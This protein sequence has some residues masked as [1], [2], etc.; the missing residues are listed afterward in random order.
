MKAAFAAWNNRI[1]PVF[2]VAHEVHV[3]EAESGRILAETRQSLPDDPPAQ[4]AVCLVES[5]VATLV[6]GAISR[7]MQALIAA[8]GIRVFPFV[9]GD[10][11]EIIDAWLSGTLRS[12]H[13]AMPGCG[14]TR[15]G[16]RRGPG[17]EENEM[18][19][20]ARGGTGRGGGRG[21]GRGRRRQAGQGAG[22]MGGPLEAGPNGFCVCPKC[23]YSEP[24][25]GGQPCFA[26]RC[27]QCGANMTRQ[28][29]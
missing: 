14:K 7:S 19:A 15:Q 25:V 22:R 16:R 10:L 1:A 6:C 27:P 9:A 26:Q 20:R 11:R 4:R 8:Y 29:S 13:Y 17:Q 5:G 18:Q 12:R 23:G 21:Q 24:H 28:A 3:V 2:D